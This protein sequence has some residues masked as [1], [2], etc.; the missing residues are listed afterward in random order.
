L[1]LKCDGKY[2]ACYCINI[3]SIIKRRRL[4]G[5][6]CD[7]IDPDRNIENFDERESISSLTRVRSP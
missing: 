6:I 2:E 5:I 4:A 7:N 3:T 1:S